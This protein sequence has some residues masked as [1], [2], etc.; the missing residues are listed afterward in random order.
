MQEYIIEMA[1]YKFEIMK[2][3]MELKKEVVMDVI[4]RQKLFD[5]IAKIEDLKKKG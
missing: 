4:I 3:K 5:E 1:K 2:V